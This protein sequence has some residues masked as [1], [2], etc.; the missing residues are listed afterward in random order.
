MG[1]AFCTVVQTK[2]N[3]EARG[4]GLFLLPPP[5]QLSLTFQPLKVTLRLIAR[6]VVSIDL[7][8]TY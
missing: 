4:R 7:S 5:P 6:S 2:H 8:A 1:F 3:N